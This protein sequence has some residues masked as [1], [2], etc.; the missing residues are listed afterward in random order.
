MLH[1]AASGFSAA[2]YSARSVLFVFLG[3]GDSRIMETRWVRIAGVVAALTCSLDELDF[4]QTLGA[5]GG[6][7]DPPA[8]WQSTSFFPTLFTAEFKALT[9]RSMQVPRN[10]SC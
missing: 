3:T 6:P 8:S 4:T 5:S 9:D 2:G 10:M 7:Q 1:C